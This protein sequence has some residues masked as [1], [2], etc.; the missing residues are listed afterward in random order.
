MRALAAALPE[1]IPTGVERADGG[2]VMLNIELTDDLVA[3][4]EAVLESA[5]DARQAI[6]GT[7]LTGT[8]ARTS[9]T[10][11][12]RT[13][14]WRRSTT[15]TRPERPASVGRP[16]ASWR[17]RSPGAWTSATSASAASSGNSWR[18]TPGVRPLG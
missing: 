17:P 4:H 6:G 15:G 7:D 16:W 5:A 2:Y 8:A 3:F 12:R 10:C 11:S 14:H 9:A 13:C 18:A 1:L